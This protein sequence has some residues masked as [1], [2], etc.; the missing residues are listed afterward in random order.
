M[1]SLNGETQPTSLRIVPCLILE[2]TFENE[3]LDASLEF[4]FAE[5]GPWTPTFEPRRIREFGLCGELL[6]LDAHDPGILPGQLIRS[7]FDVSTRLACRLPE[8][9]EQQTAW[10]REGRVAKTL[11]VQEPGSGRPITVLIRKHA[12]EHEY[13]L[14]VGMIVDWERRARVVPYERRNLAGF[15]WADP[16]Q[17][18]SPDR[19]TGTRRPL[20]RTRIDGDPNRQVAV[21]RRVG[22]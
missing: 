18:L 13:F 7:R 22:C 16:M 3:V 14:S 17:S 12:V 5:Q 6:S 4:A 10:V 11:R 15:G 8:F 20:K 21:Q 2:G 1:A 9:D 19:S